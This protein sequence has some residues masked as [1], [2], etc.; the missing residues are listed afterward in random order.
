MDLYFE[1]KSGISGDMSVA[2]LL[3]L[4]ADREKLEKALN[5]MNLNDEFSYNISKVNINAIQ[6]SD[7]DVVLKEHTHHEHG[8]NHV[9]HHHEHRNLEDVNKIID[10]AQITENAKNLA[11]KIFKIV[12]QAEAKVHGKDITEVHFHEVG[13]IDSIVDIVSFSVL[14]DDLNP[15]KVYFS[16]LTEGQGYV[17]C[18]H[19]ILPVPVPAVCEIAAEYKLPVK[20]T[21]NEG[22]MVT[23]TGAAIAAALY[24]GEKLPAEFI[25]EKIGYG[26]GK[27]KYK[28]PILRVM[29]IRG[30]N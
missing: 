22:E 19:G 9:H 10:K 4:G 5:S 21:D 28:N 12:A 6:A 16:A 20:I 23:P 13:A 8:H 1:C 25:I 7:F 15:E 26:A 14:F 18:A 29:T 3:D 11:K 2:A 27:R 24:N 30:D 17:Q